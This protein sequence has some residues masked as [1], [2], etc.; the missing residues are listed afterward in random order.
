MKFTKGIFFTTFSVIAIFS[1]TAL[2]V[3]AN[4][5]E[6][7][8]LSLSGKSTNTFLGDICYTNTTEECKSSPSSTLSYTHEPRSGVYET[9]GEDVVGFINGYAWSEYLGW[10]EFPEEGAE[11]L[12]GNFKTGCPETDKKKCYPRLVNVGGDLKIRGY[13]ALIITIVDGQTTTQQYNDYFNLSKENLDNKL[14]VKNF[15]KTN[16]EIGFSL[17]GNLDSDNS[18]IG[19]INFGTESRPAVSTQSQAP[20]PKSPELRVSKEVAVIGE[21]VTIVAKCNHYSQNISSD[22]L[23]FGEIAAITQLDGGDEIYSYRVPSADSVINFAIVCDDVLLGK[24]RKI[25]K[26]LT[27]RVQNISIDI[28]PRISRTKE[29]EDITVVGHIQIGSVPVDSISCSISEK[30][31]SVNVTPQ[32]YDISLAEFSPSGRYS[33]GLGYESTSNSQYVIYAALDANG[34]PG[35]KFVYKWISDTPSTSPTP[36][37]TDETKWRRVQEV[38]FGHLFTGI[39]GTITYEALCNVTYKGKN[40][41]PSSTRATFTKIQRG[42]VSDR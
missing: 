1:F 25:P 24:S 23:Q 21:S 4:E 2:F 33:P 38:S 5:L 42:D 17:Y 20:A 11:G 32:V 37:P 15:I 14:S 9:S 10:I 41:T 19:T 22:N 31:P 30:I 3:N 18:Q 35:D 26:H 36:L 6:K 40:P 27:V 28:D 34:V 39:V 13:A 12:G 7:Y 8:E 16:D 29:P